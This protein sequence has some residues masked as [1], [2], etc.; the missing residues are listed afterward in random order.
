[1]RQ[2]IFACDLDNT[3]LISRRHAVE[4]DLC[5]EY[6]EGMPQSYLPREAPR[7][8]AALMER[9]LFIP[10]T[11]RSVEQYRRIQFPP[12]C[13]PRYAVV[14]NGGI[15]LTDGEIDLRWRETSLEAV[16]PWREALE[17]VMGELSGRPQ[18]RRW[19]V[20][21]GLYGFAACG[22]PEEA[23]ALGEALK[24]LTPLE[25]V[26]SGRKLYALPPP[27]SKGAAAVRLK[28]W[29]QAERLICAGDSAMDIPMLELAELAI[30]PEGAA[31]GAA[32]CGEKAVCGPG[33]RFASFVLETAAQALA[34]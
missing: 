30:L 23:M 8:L 20:V 21:D 2:S 10:V 16:R 34:G 13:R 29:F 26:V 19:R 24:D 6:L 3:L 9:A 7:I 4:S 27:I 25:V 5:V 12:A 32:L 33:Q 1:M 17:T 11:S 15:L 31:P 28:E 18:A 14:A 22:G